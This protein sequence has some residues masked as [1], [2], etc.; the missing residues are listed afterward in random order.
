VIRINLLG[1]ERQVKKAVA[2]FWVAGQKLTIG[3]CLIL[4]AAVAL[5]GWRYWTLRQESQ[6]IDAAIAQAQ[7]ETARM[8]SII[9]QVQQF[10]QRRA[11][12]QQRVALIEQLRRDQTGPV[13]MLDQVGR[14]LP[15]MVWL[16]RL[17]QG[18]NAND[19]TIE[20]RGTTLTGLSDFVSNL[21]TSGYFRRSVEIVSSQSTPLQDGAGEIIQFSI[22]AQ[23][24]QPSS[25]PLEAAAPAMAA[26]PQPN[27]SQ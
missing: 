7:A 1:G 27:P 25:A 15:P 2:S 24:Q 16:T 4:V 21:E 12:L 6:R 13:H 26:A 17:Q 9:E 14:A 8:H 19:V 3:C 23:F 22:R 10:E 5:V 18:D 11:Q 20:G